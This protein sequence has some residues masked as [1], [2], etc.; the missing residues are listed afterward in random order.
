MK[1]QAKSSSSTPQNT[2][3]HLDT[4]PIEEMARHAED[5][6]HFLKLM[7]NPNRL[8]ILCH[9]LEQEMSVSEINRHVP[10][11]QSA[12]SQ[13]LAVLRKSGMVATRREQQTIHYRLADPGVRAIMDQLYAQFCA[14]GL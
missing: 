8:M 4:M 5:A 7:A 10:L 9:L 2:E 11:S 14:P 13:H 1:P 12:L 3:R 6:A